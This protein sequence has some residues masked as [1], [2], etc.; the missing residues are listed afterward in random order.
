MISTP[1]LAFDNATDASFRLWVQGLIDA[2]VAIGWIQTADT[3]Q[4]NTA[5]V[6]KPSGAT[7]TQGVA[8]FTPDDG[9]TDY[10]LKMGFGSTVNGALSPAV[11]FQLGFAT[12]GAGTFTG[13][14]TNVFRLRH[15]SQNN[16]GTS[17][18][19]MC[20]VDDMFAFSWNEEYSYLFMTNPAHQLFACERWRNAAGAP[21]TTGV[22]CVAASVDGTNVYNDTAASNAFGYLQATAAGDSG[23]GAYSDSRLPCAAINTTGSWS[24]GDK[25]GLAMLT[26][27][28]GGGLPGMGCVLACI[29]A[30]MGN[31]WGDQFEATVYGV[32]HNYRYT[33]VLIASG[34]QGYLSMIYE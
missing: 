6:L 19:H 7:Q 13:A 17:T 32:A 20:K 8:L 1:R 23:P 21:Q 29:P 22:A 12:N 4:I 14:V 33:P 24:R 25:L 34:G 3:G 10:I 9:L 16:G 11:T 18:V 15:N 27:W 26:P 2:M 30:D 5:T 31:G 28:Y